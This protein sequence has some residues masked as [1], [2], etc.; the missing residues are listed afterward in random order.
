MRLQDPFVLLAMLAVVL[1]VVGSFVRTKRRAVRMSDLGILRSIPPSAAVVLRHVL[2]VLRV[3]A[4]TLIIVALARPQKG[5]EHSR[6]KTE[7]IDIQLAVDVSTS[8]L[9]LDFHLKGER[10][11]R[12]A[13]VKDVVTDFIKRREGDRIGLTLFAARAYTQCP[14]TVDYGM[15]LTLLDR[16]KTGMIEDGTAVG[17][18][19]A[20]AVTRLKDS[21]SK[22]KV[23]VL[24]TDGVDNASKIDPVTAAQ[25]AKTFDIKIYTV[26]AG[27]RGPVLYPQ[28]GIF[29]NETLRTVTI[30]VDDALLQQIADTTGGKYFRATDT[31]SLQR[32]YEEIDRLETTEREVEQY[33]EHREMFAYCLAPALVLLLTETLLSQTRFRQLP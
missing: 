27:T 2:L 8:M 21:P 17:S 3:G 18:A 16:A 9:A 22:S 15:L 23:I 13:V 7:G 5:I 33:L 19:I 25:I 4:V 28:P 12:L 24:L 29:G 20:S 6:V 11:D 31:E 30:P 10:A 1:M 26:G 14:L 32:T